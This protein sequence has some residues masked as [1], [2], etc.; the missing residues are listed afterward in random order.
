MTMNLDIDTGAFFFNK[1]LALTPLTTKKEIMIILIG[2]LGQIRDV[3]QSLIELF[4][5]LKE[6]R[7]VIFI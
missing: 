1:M 5:T 7:M 4:L 3:I 6:T 2:R